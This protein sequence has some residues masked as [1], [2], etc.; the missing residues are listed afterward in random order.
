ME[1][2]GKKAVFLK[3]G[4]IKMKK[5][6]HFCRFCAKNARK[7]RNCLITSLSLSLSLSLW[8][9]LLKSKKEIFQKKTRFLLKNR[10]KMEHFFNV[11]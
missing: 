11:S 2:E 3:N 10:E 8:Y 9:F 1:K 5:M 7:L 6:K 4:F